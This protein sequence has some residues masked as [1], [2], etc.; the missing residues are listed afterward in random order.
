MGFDRTT[1]QVVT[2]DNATA[3]I[4]RRIGREAAHRA[5]DAL[6][7]GADENE[8]SSMLVRSE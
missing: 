4:S 2:S 1:G 7:N 5:V 8:I 6:Q 3:T